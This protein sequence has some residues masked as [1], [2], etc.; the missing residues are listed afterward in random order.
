V[1]GREEIKPT[2]KLYILKKY[3]LFTIKRVFLIKSKKLFYNKFPPRQEY[4]D[5]ATK[6]QT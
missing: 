6:E 5:I 4:P 3:C 2:N 1:S